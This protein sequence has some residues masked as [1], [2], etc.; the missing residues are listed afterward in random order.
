MRGGEWLRRNIRTILVVVVAAG[1][2][3]YLIL[4]FAIQ[5]EGR[6]E[7]EDVTIFRM[8]DVQEYVPPPPEPEP[9]PEPPEPEEVE[10]VPEEEIAEEVIETEE[11]IEETETPPPPTQQGPPGRAETEYL[12]QHMISAAPKIPMDE[13]RDN[14]E[15]PPLANRQRIEG[16]VYL[17]LYI[18]AEGTIRDIKVLRDPGYGLGDAAVAAFDGVTVTP[19]EA[20]DAPVAVRFR[21]PVRFQLR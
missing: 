16:V 8:V 15:Y 9:E 21:F 19:A 11:E 3:L 18:D 20:N 13:V 4:T 2:H 14:I 12:P 17:E 10:E 5:T 7:R 1:L 6:E